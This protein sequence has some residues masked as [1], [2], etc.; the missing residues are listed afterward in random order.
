MP[1]DYGGSESLDD[2]TT[3]IGFLE[4]LAESDDHNGIVLLGDF[5]ADL[6][7]MK[8]RFARNLD[9]FVSE[10]RMVVVGVGDLAHIGL[11]TWHSADFA[12]QTWI[13][14]FVV[15]NSLE[16]MVAD[17]KAI[18]D[19]MFVS[20]HWP[21]VMSVDLQVETGDKGD[22]CQ[23]NGRRLLWRQATV[24]N[25]YK[26]QME[27][28]LELSEID[29]PAE[30]ATCNE[31]GCCDHKHILQ[32]YLDNI[33]A[34][35]IRCGKRFI[36]RARTQCGRKLGWNVDLKA[37][38]QDAR[39]AYCLWRDAGRPRQGSF[40]SNMKE[41]RKKFKCKLKN[42]KR[43]EREL[44]CNRLLESVD[45]DNHESF[46]KKLKSGVQ[47]IR[48]KQN[49]WIQQVKS[50][51]EILEV[52]KRHFGDILN[53]EPQENVDRE[54]SL[55]ERTLKDCIQSTKEP[56]WFVEIHPLEVERAIK[57]L[58]ETKQLVLI[59]LKLSI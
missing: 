38:K 37:T 52:W 32:S 11:N 22:H 39:K 7:Q 54:R 45:E 16:C 25:L 30:A 6:R 24:N 57:C 2:Y 28:D 8:R 51:E 20:D 26:Y 10:H 19:G 34:A 33:C 21:I 12:S 40:Y 55:F 18:E 3:E 53:S 41:S 17:F 15:S 42:R 36:P 58:K 59:K 46:W 50:E 43:E 47:P 27:L 56:W 23:A 13:D 14:Y 1:V 5:N 49:A 35:M 29:I 31:P 48:S 9:T 4:S 44:F